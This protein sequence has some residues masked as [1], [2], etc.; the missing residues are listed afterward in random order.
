MNT[1]RS[2]RH[3][4]IARLRD[5]ARSARTRRDVGR[6][7]V[8]GPKL[9]DEAIRADLGIAA[10]YVDENSEIGE[11][12]SEKMRAN[13]I[14]IRPVTQRAI[15]RIS[16][17]KTPQ[18]V[19]A[20]VEIKTYDWTMLDN[21]KSAV[22][23]LVAVDMNDPG[24]LGTLIRTARANAFD[25]VVL[26]GNTTAVMAPKVIRSSA[27]A[28]F[29]VPVIETELADVI[30][31]LRARQ[32]CSIGTRMSNAVD[33]DQLDLAAS[34][35][36]I[37]GNEANGLTDDLEPDIWATIPMKGQTESLNVAMAGTIFAYELARQRRNHTKICRN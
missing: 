37:L 10:V 3:P 25:A 9:I 4:E 20:E 31:Q 17:T 26:A 33:C 5:L 23:V 29:H 30:E 24:N 22:A 14:E 2:H 12:L 8:E 18:P 21:P 28:V 7:V 27:G 34:S 35:A 11:G 13:G 36:I 15:E 19:L 6:C 16:T 1:A 32:I